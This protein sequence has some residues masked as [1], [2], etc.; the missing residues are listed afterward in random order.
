ME[1]TAEGELSVGPPDDP[2]KWWFRFERGD[3]VAIHGD[4]PF[5]SSLTEVFATHPQARNLAELGVGTNEKAKPCDSILEAE[6]TLG[7]VHLAVGDNAGF[8]GKVAV[9]YHRDFIVY[10]PTLVLRSAAG[11]RILVDNGTLQV[12]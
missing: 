5:G 2:G 7:T 4:P 9:P 6:K 3:L 1:G 12:D 8:G 10:G 11:E